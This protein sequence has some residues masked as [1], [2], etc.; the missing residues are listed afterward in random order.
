MSATLEPNTYPLSLRPS[1]PLPGPSSAYNP[2]SG[3]YLGSRAAL[4]LHYI[5]HPHRARAVAS[6]RMTARPTCWQMRPVPCRPSP[7]PSRMLPNRAG[8]AAAV[9]TS[10]ARQSPTGQSRH[11]PWPDLC[12]CLG[13]REAAPRDKAEA[14]QDYS[15]RDTIKKANT[16]DRPGG[17]QRLTANLPSAAGSSPGPGRGEMSDPR[18]GQGLVVPRAAIDGRSRD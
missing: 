15:R 16:L 10:L 9:Q 5:T 18:F 3:T 17:A 7:S 2:W 4:V 6:G 13:K 11:R 1:S 12:A 8:G 14:N